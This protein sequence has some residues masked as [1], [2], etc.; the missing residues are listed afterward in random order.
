MADKSNWLRNAVLNAV[1][2][3]QSLNVSSVYMSLHSSNPG[4]NGSN[5]L[6][7]G[8]YSRQEVT[9]G[10]VSSGKVSNSAVIEFE[11]IPGQPVNYV[12]LWSASTGGNFLY[13][14]IVTFS[15]GQPDEGDTVQIEVGSL[16]IEEA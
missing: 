5:E 12:G 10:S 4:L 11:D 8:G 1:C 15:E 14:G 3:G 16:E 6:S 2:K 13:R 9:F 7:G